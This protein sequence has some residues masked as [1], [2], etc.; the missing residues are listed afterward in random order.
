M[1]VTFTPQLGQF[2]LALLG[3]HYWLVILIIFVVALFGLAK[4]IAAVADLVKSW[5]TP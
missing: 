2:L 4:L 1:E 3:H 5:R